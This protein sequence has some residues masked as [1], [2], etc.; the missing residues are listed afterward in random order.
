MTFADLPLRPSSKMLRQFAGAWLVFVGAAAAHQALVRGHVRAGVILGA[1]AVVI[2]LL[3][4]IRPQAVRW[5]FVGLTVLAFPIGWVV[6]Q[7]MLIILF[8]GLL[9]P[10]ALIFR[11]RGRDVLCRKFPGSQASYWTEK[12]TPTDVRRYFRTY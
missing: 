12:T 6:T 2:S 1:A 11:L 4:L 10:V 7:L 9:T 5:L 3:G 8:Y